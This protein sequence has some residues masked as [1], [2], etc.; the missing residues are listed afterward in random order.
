MKKNDAFP[1]KFWKVSDLHG[2]SITVIIDHVES[3]DVGGETK[4]VVYFRG[5]DKKFVLNRTN[6]EAIEEISGTDDTDQWSGVVIVLKPSRVD[7]KGKRVDAIRIDIDASK[8]VQQ[9]PAG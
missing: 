5:K 3:E 9:V 4:P 7:F 6:Y 1:S 2:Q 8:R